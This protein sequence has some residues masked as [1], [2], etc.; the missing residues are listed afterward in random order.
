MKVL[1]NNKSISQDLI[2]Y[3]PGLNFNRFFN[4][5]EIVPYELEVTKSYF[6]DKLNSFHNTVRA[7]IKKDDE[8][9]K[10][11]LNF[12]EVN[13]PS[14]SEL[15]QFPKQLKEIFETYLKDEFFKNFINTNN[16]YN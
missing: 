10:D 15:L 4:D 16:L 11:S 8:K 3:N 9:Y 5:S 6:L 12:R 2:S 13:Y 7:E 14:L 1:V